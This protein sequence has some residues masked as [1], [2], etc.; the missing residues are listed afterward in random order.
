MVIAA[1][2][3]KLSNFYENQGFIMVL[4]RA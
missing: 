1:E 4:V 2:L 3:V